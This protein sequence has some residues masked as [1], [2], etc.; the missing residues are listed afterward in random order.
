ML[1]SSPVCCERGS[2]IKEQP[3]P[4]VTAV[5]QPDEEA[6]EQPVI[7]L[8][9]LT[10]PS[11]G[12][13]PVITSDSELA[14]AATALRNGVGPVALDAERASGHRYGQ[15]AYLIQLRREGA[16]SFLI[17][18]IA[19]PDLHDI[20]ASIA[21]AEWI[22]HAASQDLACLAEVGLEPHAGLFD[23]EIAARLLNRP[24]V[25]LA[26]LVA[27]Y[28]GYSLAKEHSAVDWSTRPLPESWLAYA[29][30]DVELLIPLADMLRE[31]LASAGKTQWA[32]QE[33]EHTIKQ[34]HA[35]AIPKVDP[36]RRSS[37]L[38][39]IRHRKGLAVVETMWNERDRLAR[40][41]DVHPSRVL[42][43]AAIVAA[44]VSLPLSMPAL[45]ALPEFATR[46]A[47]RHIRTWLRCMQQAARTPEADWPPFGG[48]GDSIPQPRTWAQREP[49]AWARLERSRVALS[50]HA[51]EL[52]LPLENLIKPD[53]VRRVC[54]QP[55]DDLEGYLS[56]LSVRPWQIDQTADILRKCLNPA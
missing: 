25:G 24:R 7:E 9:A 38:H 49:A 20:D 51:E 46:G 56:S 53:V 4:T 39:K 26:A 32:H 48:G 45:I 23:T 27:D 10:M 5:T 55:P 43:D 14:A 34:S 30:L 3:P 22:L 15:R 40:I 16:G 41:N 6:H 11:Q 36:W 52:N 35:D 44:A 50:S 54:W 8:I 42:S 13:L 21:D 18:P 31:E 17:D 2:S 29:A 19:Q 37:G 47:G 33:C 28:F 12:R 1:P